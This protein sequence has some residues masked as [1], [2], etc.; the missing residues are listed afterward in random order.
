[1]RK[2]ELNSFTTS[3]IRF[4]SE[5]IGIPEN[6]FKKEIIGL[7]QNHNNLLRVYLAQVAYDEVKDFNVALCIASVCGEDEKFTHNASSLF[8]CMFGSH[9]HLDI[10]YLSVSQEAQLRKVCCPFFN[11]KRYDH[12]DFYLTSSEGYNLEQIR[13]CY[14]EKRFMGNH[15][16][17][18]MLC[19][20]IPPILGQPY[21]LGEQNIHNVV[22]A[23]RHTD[24]SIFVIN[25]WPAYV[26]VARLTGYI[27]SDKFVITENDIESIGWAEIYESQASIKGES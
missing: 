11:Y 8:C 18:Y 9:E 16:D 17:G 22:F 3:K 21:G 4:L 12:P 20:I 24:Y 26:H 19:E 25:D 10:L 2:E 27:E 23:S 5:Q 6:E 1:M 14:K 7:L 15:P 13:A